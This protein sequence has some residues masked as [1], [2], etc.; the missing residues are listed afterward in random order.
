VLE[1]AMDCGIPIPRTHFVDDITDLRRILPRVEYPAVVK[2]RWSRILT[3]DGWQATTAQY[4]CSEAELRRLYDE[5]DYL[6][7]KPSL[8][9]ER[10]HGSGIGVF[11]LCDRGTVLTAFAHRRLREKP[12]SGGVSVLCESLPLDASLRDEASRLVGPIGWQGVAMVEYKLDQRTGRPVLMEVNGRFW[13]SLQ[14]A[15]DAGVDFPHLYYQLALGH[16]PSLPSRYEIGVKSR[17]LVG[18]FDHLL[19]RLF[20]DRQDDELH[21]TS[22]LRALVTFLTAGASSRVRHDVC[23]PDDPRPMLHELWQYVGAAV[24]GSQAPSVRDHAVTKMS[25]PLGGSNAGAV[26]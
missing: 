18:D 9:Q 25:A 13:G 17:W 26:E 2:S 20:K 4:A 15:V 24:R 8:I 23:R 10:I 22:R 5:V 16:P 6:S 19:I 1:R 21:A 11:L 12:P 14:L 7:S 3:D